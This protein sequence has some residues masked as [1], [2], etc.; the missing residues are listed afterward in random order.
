MAA[1]PYEPALVMICSRLLG[2]KD[3]SSGGGVAV[4]AACFPADAAALV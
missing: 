4:A 2:L 3:F 1:I